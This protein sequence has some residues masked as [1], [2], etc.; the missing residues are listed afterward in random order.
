VQA[1]DHIATAYAELRNANSNAKVKNLTSHYRAEI[2]FTSAKFDRYAI[3]FRAGV[4][5]FLSLPEL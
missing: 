1:S 3:F 2:V 4:E 5:L